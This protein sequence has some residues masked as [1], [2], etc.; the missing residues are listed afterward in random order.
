M[1]LKYILLTFSPSLHAGV[2][3]DGGDAGGAGHGLPRRVVLPRPLRGR[4]ALLLRHVRR[5]RLG[6]GGRCRRRERGSG[7]GGD[8]QGDWEHSSGG[9]AGEERRGEVLG[10]VEGGDGEERVREG[11]DERQRHGAGAVDSQHAP[12][13][14]RLHRH[15]WGWHT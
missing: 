12:A 8:G 7:G 11:R 1:S 6:R 4:P 10:E 9:R 5:G 15:A 3:A 2:G 13:G 14:E